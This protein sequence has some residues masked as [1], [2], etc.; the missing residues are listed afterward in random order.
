[1]AIT[2][3]TG[4]QL[5]RNTWAVMPT[6][7][8]TDV[9]LGTKFKP[10]G[11]DHKLLVL[12]ENADSGNSQI[13]KILAGE[14]PMAGAALSRTVVA[15]NK[16]CIVIESGLYMHDDGYIYAQGYDTDG[17]TASADVKFAFIQLP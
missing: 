17:T 1:M 11:P 7:A 9:T 12:V 3:L 16:E 14:G 5:V 13:A 4:T 6:A 15:S 8:A 2:T 10:L